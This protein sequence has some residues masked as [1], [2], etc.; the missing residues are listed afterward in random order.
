[1]GG[2]RDGWVGVCVWRGVEGVCVEGCLCVEA[3]GGV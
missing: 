3:C 1:M 2:W